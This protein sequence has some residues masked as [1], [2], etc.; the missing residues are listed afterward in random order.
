LLDDR[1][2]MRLVVVLLGAVWLLMPVFLLGSLAE[3][4]VPFVVGGEIALEDPDQLYP[5]GG[6]TELG[7]EFRRRACE[8]LETPARCQASGTAFL[9]P[10]TAIPVAVAVSWPSVDVGAALLRFVGVASAAAALALAWRDI[11]DRGP[12]APAAVAG[13]A[14]AFSPLVGLMAGLGQTTALLLLAAAA[15]APA[16]TRRGWLAVVAWGAVS[17]LKAFPTIAVV[18][19]RRQAGR[20][21][22]L[23]VGAL[24]AMTV[25]GLVIAGPARLPE[26][27]DATSRV[28]EEARSG[29]RSGSL[30]S[31]TGLVVDGA[32]AKSIV[33]WALRIPLLVSL[34]RGGRR[35]EDGVRWSFALLAAVLVVPQVWV[36]YL[37]ALPAVGHALARRRG[38]TPYLVACLATLPGAVLVA[39][40][41]GGDALVLSVSVPLVAGAV[42]AASVASGGA[43]DEAIAA[44]GR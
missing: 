14:L 40:D 1:S 10:P 5:E 35:A 38:P 24:A 12:R 39:A 27:L 22:A 18:A 23:V 25:L 21:V 13:A 34:W 20:P 44:V 15:G 28:A 3:D 42:W 2:A 9:S 4:A 36:H 37:V 29:R 30:E 17:A 16:A 41:V 31:L 26:F 7:P 32:A 11:A 33:A 43:R 19:V 6:L 8:L